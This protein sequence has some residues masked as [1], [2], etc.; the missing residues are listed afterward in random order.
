MNVGDRITINRDLL[1]QMNDTTD[2]GPGTIVEVV[3]AAGSYM[4]KWDDARQN[5][6]RAEFLR[7]YQLSPKK[8]TVTATGCRLL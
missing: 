4:V 2:P 5:G 6:G 3:V 8:R 7:S 1:G